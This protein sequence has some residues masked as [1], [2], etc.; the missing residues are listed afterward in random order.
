[1]C[2]VKTPCARTDKTYIHGK[3]Y[4]SSDCVVR[5]GP[6]PEFQSL[7]SSKCR[8]YMQ[9]CVI[10]IVW[11]GPTLQDEPHRSYVAQS[12]SSTMGTGIS[13]RLDMNCIHH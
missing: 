1:M 12:A 10:V 9:G 13:Q 11:R 7:R 2:K 4:R 5:T 6:I 3:T 8:T